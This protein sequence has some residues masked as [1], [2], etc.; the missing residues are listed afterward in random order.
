MLIFKKPK[1]K[2]YRANFLLFVCCSFQKTSLSTVLLQEFKLGKFFG[3]NFLG[4]CGAT[5]SASAK[6]ARRPGFKSR[7]IYRDFRFQKI[8]IGD[9]ILQDF[10]SCSLGTSRP[11][12]ITLQ[13]SYS[14]TL[15]FNEIAHWRTVILTNLM[16]HE[17]S[18]DVQSVQKQP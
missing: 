16:V 13:R 5:D 15:H 8:S 11:C 17:L 14:C 3:Q 12:W 7:W 6:D 18:D 10:K 1:I 9:P 4:L 2:F